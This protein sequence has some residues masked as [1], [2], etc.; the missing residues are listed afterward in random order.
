MQNFAEALHIYTNNLAFPCA[1]SHELTQSG[2]VVLLP[3][4]CRTMPAPVLVLPAEAPG[5]QF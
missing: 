2:M 3:C 1:I 5:M 4:F